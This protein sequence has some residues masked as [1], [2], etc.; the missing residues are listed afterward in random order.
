MKK[1]TDYI[2]NPAVIEERKMNAVAMDIYSRMLMD[3]IVFLGSHIDSDVANAVQAQ[4][5]YLASLDEKADI[6]LYINSPGGEVSAGLAI[7]DTMQLIKPD[8]ATVCT[9]MA[10]SMAAVLLSA[11]ARGKRS[12]L[13][14]SRVMIHQPSGGARGMASDVLIAAREMEKTRGELCSILSLHTGRNY[15]RLLAD[16]DR[17][18]WM[19]AAEALE[20]GMVDTI[21]N[22]K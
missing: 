8:V 7:Y 4:L 6:T 5:L 21:H 18:C 15:D 13:P 14:H 9:G 3:R 12:I 10:A 2:I 20:Y 16:M 11:G 22:G 17:D 1:I 19:N